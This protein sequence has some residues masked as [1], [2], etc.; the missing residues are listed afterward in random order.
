MSEP[1]S[2]CP[3][4]RCAHI[5]LALVL[6]LG[7]ALPLAV[8]AWHTVAREWKA[9]RQVSQWKQRGDA[10]FLA[11][12][13]ATAARTY[14]RAQAI[15]PTALDLLPLFARARA[16]DAAWHPDTLQGDY[17]ADVAVDV[18]SV[19]AAFPADKPTLTALRGFVAIQAGRT[20]DGEALVRKALELD[21]ANGPANLGLAHILRR[22]P[23]KMKETV[24][25]MEAAIKAGPKV[26]ENLALLGRILLDQGD[27]KGAT[28]RLTESVALRETADS[29]RDLGTALLAGNDLPGAIKRLGDS[30]RLN[31]R[32]ATTWSLLSQAYLMDEAFDSAE[33]AARTSL[34]IQQAPA[35][36]I[37]LAQAL[38]RQ[39]RFGEAAQLLQQ[40]LQS[41]R[42]L[43]TLIEFASALEGLNRTNDALTIYREILSSQWPRD[44]QQSRLVQQI[45][46]I[47]LQHVQAL[48]P[49]APAVPAAPGPAKKGAK[50]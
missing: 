50:R 28:D 32:A 13:F 20:S 35:T 8:A 30:A 19:E 34:A 11:G 17:V 47:A 40:T 24:A 38:N 41:Q 15:D 3:R 22:D 31:D 37:R 21:P 2:T 26:P 36:T 23:G 25:A 5:I 42:D 33:T 16:F 10:A 7:L 49:A 48:N 27:V 18:D 4:C 44:P 45:Q 46:S 12:D 29:L 39:K 9:C 14:S 43:V 1:Q 6:G